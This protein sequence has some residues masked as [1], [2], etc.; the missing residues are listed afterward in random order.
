MQDG[1][2]VGHTLVFQLMLSRACTEPRLPLLLML[3]GQRGGWGCPRSWGDT[4]RP[5]EPRQPQGHAKPWG[6]VTSPDT[7]AAGWGLLP[8]RAAV[9]WWG[10]TA[11]GI[12]CLF[13]FSVLVTLPLSQPTSSRASFS[14]SLPVPLRE[15]GGRAV[16]LCLGG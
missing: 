16:L 4:A 7:G 11:L 15:V 12:T 14:S 13:C 9:G 5:A 1:N 10:A 2:N 8:L 3:S 6:A